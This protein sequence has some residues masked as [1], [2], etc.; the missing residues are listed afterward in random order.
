[1]R[2]QSVNMDHEPGVIGTTVTIVTFILTLITKSDILF[3]VS[4]IAG[5]TTI[6]INIKRLREKPKK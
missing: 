3:T 4:L 5:L 1:M 6:A 2:T